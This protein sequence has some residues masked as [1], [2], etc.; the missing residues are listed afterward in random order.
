MFPGL[1]DGADERDVR[2]LPQDGPD[3]GLRKARSDMVLLLNFA[4]KKSR[5]II[6]R[7]ERHFVLLVSPAFPALKR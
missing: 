5:N 2:P 4:K 1:G 7:V 6:L 3:C